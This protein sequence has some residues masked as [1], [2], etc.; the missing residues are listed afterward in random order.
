MFACT[1]TGTGL[2]SEVSAQ[3]STEKKGLVQ[4]VMFSP[5]RPRDYRFVPDKNVST[6]KRV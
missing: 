3:L 5:P 1:E 2:I 4:D 6:L